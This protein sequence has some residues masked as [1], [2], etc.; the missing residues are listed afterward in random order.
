[1]NEEAV[2]ISLENRLGG[3]AVLE[4]EAPQFTN[5]TGEKPLSNLKSSRIFETDDF[6]KW[7]SRASEMRKSAELILEEK[8][9][10]IAKNS[11]NSSAETLKSVTG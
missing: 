4:E 7:V 5:E 8:E 6:E 9:K 11:E 10:I 2:Q 3:L 1:M